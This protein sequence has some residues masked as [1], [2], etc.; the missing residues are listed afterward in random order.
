MSSPQVPRSIPEAYKLPVNRLPIPLSMT[1]ADRRKVTAGANAA[2]AVGM[3]TLAD[4]FALGKDRM[5]EPVSRPVR[6][7]DVAI[8]LFQT[9]AEACVEREIPQNSVPPEQWLA[10]YED[11]RNAS[12]ATLLPA[13]SPDYHFPTYASLD[14]GYG[15]TTIGTFLRPDFADI[16]ITG[17][18]DHMAASI[19]PSPYN[20]T[21]RIIEAT[22]HVDGLIVFREDVVLPAVTQFDQARAA[23]QP[24]QL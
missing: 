23:G 3:F 18:R 22:T 21:K 9:V 6:V 7:P 16:V 8:T 2:R 24:P 11:F 20:Q 12:A 19:P 5:K 13:T 1:S 15:E 14:F 4:T 17:V 10:L